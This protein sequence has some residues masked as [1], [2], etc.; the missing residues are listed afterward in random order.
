M[1]KVKVIIANEDG[2]VL[3]LFWIHQGRA[4]TPNRLAQIVR[5]SIER[6][7]NVTNDGKEK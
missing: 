7:F 5:D 3:D 4:A 6:R 1:T 2:E